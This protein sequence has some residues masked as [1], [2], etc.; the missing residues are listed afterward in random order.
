MTHRFSLLG[1][2]GLV[3]G[4]TTGAASVHATTATRLTYVTFNGPVALPGVT[5]AAGTYAF[6]LAD[7][8][9]AG[10]V[11][12]VRNKA[13]TEQYFMGFTERIARPGG[14]AAD[15]SMSFAE[16]RRG[17]A[18]RIIAWY[19]PDSASGLKFIYPR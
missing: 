4:I 15:T 16:A 2:L 13:R 1:T 9:G 19:L 7:P 6:E 8:T 17:D 18:R 5:L 3:L 11:V 10:T 14:M 12:A